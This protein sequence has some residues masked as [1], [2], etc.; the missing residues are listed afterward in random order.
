MGLCF[1]IGDK[2]DVSTGHLFMLQKA[3]DTIRLRHTDYD[4]IDF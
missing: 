2:K 4:K 1:A 3:T